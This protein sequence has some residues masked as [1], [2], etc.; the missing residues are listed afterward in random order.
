MVFFTSVVSK[1][2]IPRYQDLFINSDQTENRT[3]H[4]ILSIIEQYK[5]QP[6]IIAINNQMNQE[7]L[8]ALRLVRNQIFQQNF[9][10]AKSDIFTEVIHMKLNK[11][12]VVGNFLCNMKLANVTPVYE[13]GNRSKKGNYQTA[14]ILQNISK[15]F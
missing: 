9:I 7:I 13:K 5:I 4:P 14:G 12:L 6:S 2:N 15:V 3:G 1:L 8:T 11:G 10:K